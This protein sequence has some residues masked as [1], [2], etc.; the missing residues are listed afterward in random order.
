MTCLEIGYYSL[1]EDSLWILCTIAGTEKLC[2]RIINELK[3]Y[4]RNYDRL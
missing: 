1:L 3:Y 4:Y 2:E